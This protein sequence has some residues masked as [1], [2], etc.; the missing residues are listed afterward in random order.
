MP[1]VHFPTCRD[2]LVSHGGMTHLFPLSPRILSPFW[3][4]RA[5]DP[6]W[7]PVCLSS[8]LELSHQEWLGRISL[9]SRDEPGLPE[10]RKLWA[11][12]LC[13]GGQ[14]DPSEEAVGRA[15]I[16]GRVGEV[17]VRSWEAGLKG[18]LCGF[19]DLVLCGPG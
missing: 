14:R 3:L 16:A 1:A 10:P 6:T 13:S 8:G 17:T 15:D 9:S 7:D 12:A 11:E 2:G 19:G 5:S 4:N 18:Q